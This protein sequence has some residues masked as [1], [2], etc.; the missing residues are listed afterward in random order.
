MR[1]STTASAAFLAGSV[2]AHPHAYPPLNGLSKRKLDLNSFR[3]ET[4]TEY[5]DTAATDS[6]PIVAL[7]KR[8]TYLETATALV[9]K[10]VPGAEFRVA[11]DHYVGTN[12]IA[13]VNL[14]Q[15][16]HGLD[17][18]NADFNV[19][20]AADGSVFSFGNSFYTGAIPAEN[21]LTK[22]DQ[23]DPVAA[24]KGASSVLDLSITATAAVAKPEES[25]EHY[26]IEGSQGALSAP[27]ARLQYIL[28]P[29]NTLALVWRVETDVGSDWLL[30]YV[31]AADSSKIHA[32][33]N[34]VA[35]ASPWE[36]ND[37]SKGSRVT[38]SNPANTAS[39]PLGW[40]NDGTTT[41]T[42]TH[43][44]NGIAQANYAGDTAYLSDYRPSGGSTNDYLFGLNLANTNPQ[45][46]SNA[47][48]TQLF[49][50][51]N[52]YH[53][54]LYQ[55]GFTSAA[56]NFQTSVNGG[57]G[58]GGDEVILNAQDGAGT[59]NAD[60][61]TPVDGQKPRM[62]MF[63][64]D[65]T[66]PK[67]DCA[68]D[69]GVIIHEY[70]H[71]VSNRLTGGPANSNCLSV[72]EAGGM[73]EGWGDFMAIAIHLKTSDKRTTN[74]PL[75]DWIYGNPAGIR[76][77]LYSTSLTTNPLTYAK[78]NGVSEVHAIGTT[79]AT[80]LYELLWNIID[81]KGITATRFPVL[82]AKG[83]PTDGRFYTMKIVI[84]AMAFPTFVS[85]RD[86]ILDADKNLSGGANACAIWT[87]FAKRGV[88]S[89]A[90]RGTGNSGRTASNVIPT[91]VC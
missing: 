70:T 39:S 72:L 65:Y 71:G 57:G 48:V 27:K 34:Y 77:Y 44:N 28:T 60:F 56:G 23:I 53:D 29:E 46:Y 11:D 2:V 35:E 17:I 21:P 22:R 79:W 90:K 15:T 73:G 20:V 25:L 14:K 43:G 52:L 82:D 85:G 33:V 81:K 5:S 89:G 26:V 49:Y 8:E 64:W 54:L 19:N 50:T 1:F 86:A 66:T 63:I 30:T 6:T 55:L 4:E 91:G 3:L 12:G 51:A 40:H 31:D 37:P 47:S 78:V 45:T 62:R 41:Y 10:T 87:A 13:H 80:I 16:V 36:T 84:D 58:K 7:V 42:V 9:Q 74:Y 76:Q 32:A 38:E 18:D 67:R 68:F 24:L 69:A 83:A 59:D 75:G 88:G 61:A